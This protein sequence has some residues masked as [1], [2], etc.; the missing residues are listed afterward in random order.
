[1]KLTENFY[2]SEFESKDGA[3]MPK[4]VL[5]NVKKLAKQLQILRD[6]TNLPIK[7]NSGYRSANHNSN[8]GGSKMSRHLY[9]Y[10]SDIVIQGFAP[11][12]T[13]TLIEY[14]IGKGIMKQGGLGK[15]K[16]FTHYDIYFDGTCITKIKSSGDLIIKG[17]IITNES[18]PCSF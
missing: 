8:V 4:E 11:K 17:D 12:D 14:L 13:Y 15:Y 10:A 2:K 3:E 6:Y 5:K 9:G 18:N 1:M 7:I 16:T